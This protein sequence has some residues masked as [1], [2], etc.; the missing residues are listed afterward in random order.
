MTALAPL[1]LLDEIAAHFDPS[2]REAL[3]SSL[4]QSGAQV[5]MTGADPTAFVH[6][7]NRAE[8]FQVEQGKVMKA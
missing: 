3:F 4:E 7:H 2:R 1:I 8:I 5:W 6:L